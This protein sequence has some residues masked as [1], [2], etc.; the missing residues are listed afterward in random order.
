M[1]LL[2]SYAKWKRIDQPQSQNQIQ[3]IMN[4]ISFYL[5]LLLI[6]FIFP[7]KALVVPKPKCIDNKIYFRQ[8]K[9]T[10][11]GKWRRGRMS[12][13]R[14]CCQSTCEKVTQ[15]SRY[16]SCDSKCQ[17]AIKRNTSYIKIQKSHIQHNIS[18]DSV[19]GT[20]DYSE[21][22]MLATILRRI[23]QAASAQR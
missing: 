1:K 13:F 20:D 23:P 21:E 6:A 17:T 18:I 19:H 14:C 8:K 12:R 7:L 10:H 5:P 3:F 11:R 9:H 15:H 2:I 4:S 16:G 22:T